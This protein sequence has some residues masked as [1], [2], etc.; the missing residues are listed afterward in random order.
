MTLEK[1]QETRGRG[2]GR[3]AAEESRDVRGQLILAARDL[4]TTHGFSAVSTRQLAVAAGATP[5]MIHYYFGDKHGLY[6]AL[7]EEVIPPVLAEL[8][9]REKGT[10][11]RL[12]VA[13]FMRAYLTMFRD[14]PWLPPLVFREMHE[15]ADFQR[16]FVERFASRARQLL[17]SALEN[18]RQDG[19]VRDGL[20][21]NM[22]L[23]SVMS[24]CVFPFLARPM[25]E[26]VLDLS[27]DENFV[28]Q[29]SRYASALFYR[30]VQP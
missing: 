16:H 18:D 14:N 22:A 8:E 28:R 5:A 3:P 30:G 27:M 20:D 4:F 19:R 11:S 26:K 2:G 9:A 24:L 21:S 1:G 25:L 6:R 23:A 7:L 13:D 17:G 29:W 10:N 12:S 15:A